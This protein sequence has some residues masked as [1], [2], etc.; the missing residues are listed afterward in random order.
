MYMLLS[1]NLAYLFICLFSTCISACSFLMS[2][3]SMSVMYSMPYLLIWFLMYIPW[4]RVHI[5]VI[6]INKFHILLSSCL[7]GVDAHYFLRFVA[8]IWKYSSSLTIEKS[9]CKKLRAV[10][11]GK[12][13]FCIFWSL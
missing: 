2:S 12:H 9:A 7:V 3:C 8:A 13:L 5:N 4:L 6:L 11:L 1:F 10:I